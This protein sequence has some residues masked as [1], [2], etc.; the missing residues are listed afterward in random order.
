[1]PRR[2][3]LGERESQMRATRERIVEAAIELSIEVGITKA[4]MRQVG[5]RADVAPGT[6]RNHFPSRVALEEAMVER[7]TAEGP[8]PD[9]SIFDGAET[10]PDRV[11]RFLAVTGTFFGQAGRL[12]R[13]W[14]REPMLTSPWTEAGARYGAR[15]AE[16]QRLALGP[17]ADDEEVQAVFRAIMAPPFFDALRGGARTTEEAGILIAEA[18]APWLQMRAG[19]SPP[20]A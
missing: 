12:Y 3:R 11:G 8:L 16:L 7:L 18:L 6:L 20:T 13:M 5:L 15:W 1:M 14:L 10:L 4:T 2:Y 17:L 19:T 9:A